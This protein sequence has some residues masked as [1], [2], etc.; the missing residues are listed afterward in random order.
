M[1]EI[2]NISKAVIKRI[3]GLKQKKNRDETGLF[4][5]E[6]EKCIN[7][8][9]EAFP[10]VHYLT[11]DNTPMRDL[12][13]LSS[14]RTPQGFIAVFKQPLYHLQ[15]IDYKQLIVVLDGIQDPGNMGTILRTCDWFGIQ[16]VVCSAQTVDC[17]SQKVV[18]ASMGALAHVR[19]HY[20]PTLT[21][22]LNN[23]RLS[24]PDLPFY[25]TLLDGNNLYEQ[26][27]VP[28]KKKGLIIMGNEGNGITKEVR[29][30]IT[31]SLY[32]P[33]YS[34][35]HIESLNVGIATA[36]ILAYFRLKENEK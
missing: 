22:Y 29:R 2:E 3:A 21:E 7:E 8:L 23:V 25:G 24:H 9:K 18:Q 20:V 13:R 15:Q 34:N 14:L 19:V 32:I 26:D 30:Q 35:N 27:A 17:F 16:D 1:S 11:P 6:G 33:S 36:I 31:H 12:E 4:V 10:I 5:A 28:Q